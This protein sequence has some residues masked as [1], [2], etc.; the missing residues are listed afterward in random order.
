LLIF[1]HNKTLDNTPSDHQLNSEARF[2]EL[3]ERIARG[4][5]DVMTC[6]NRYFHR[7]NLKSGTGATGR[8]DVQ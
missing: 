6:S 4:L 2:M 1:S 8:Q 7:L 3:P 5:P